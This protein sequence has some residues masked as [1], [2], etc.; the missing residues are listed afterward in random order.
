ML[1]LSWNTLLIIWIL[2]SAIAALVWVLVA[3]ARAG[4]QL[5]EFERQA[6]MSPRDETIGRDQYQAEQHARLATLQKDRAV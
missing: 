5:W 2:S 4:R 1:G 3:A 6:P